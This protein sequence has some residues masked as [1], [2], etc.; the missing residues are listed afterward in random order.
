[1]EVL[2]KIM[3]LEELIQLEIIEEWFM[4]SEVGDQ[5]ITLVAAF[6]LLAL[7]VVLITKKFKIPIVVG[8]VF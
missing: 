5:V 3:A 2:D 8:Y 6:F 7:F 4:V 1:M